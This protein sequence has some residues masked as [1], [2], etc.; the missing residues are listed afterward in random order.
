[1]KISGEKRL[2]TFGITK[3][4]ATAWDLFSLSFPATSGTA[5]VRGMIEDGFFIS[6]PFH[7]GLIGNYCTVT[8]DGSASFP[9]CTCCDNLQNSD[10]D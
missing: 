10:A 4:T 3:G 9:A 8:N 7:F 1:M 2:E 5:E 6:P